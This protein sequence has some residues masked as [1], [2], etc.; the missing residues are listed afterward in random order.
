MCQRKNDLLRT[1]L[2]T[3]V[4]VVTSAVVVTRVVVVTGVGTIIVV[5]AVEVFCIGDY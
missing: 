1:V 3:T 2:V 4:A 5:D